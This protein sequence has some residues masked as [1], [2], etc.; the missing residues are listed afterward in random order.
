MLRTYQ[1]RCRF[2]ADVDSVAMSNLIVGITTMDFGRFIAGSE[3]TVEDLLA[4]GVP[5]LGLL[6]GATL[7]PLPQPALA[8]G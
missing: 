7:A 4:A 6:L 8:N 1:A 5:H 2:L 3:G